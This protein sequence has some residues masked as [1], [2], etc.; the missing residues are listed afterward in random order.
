[1]FYYTFRQATSLAICTIRQSLMAR[2]VGENIGFGAIT[3]DDYIERH[4]TAFLNRLYNGTPQNPKVIVYNDCTYLDIEKSSCFK[5]LRQS[6]CVHKSRHLVKPS[7]LVA[8]DGYLL[9]I[10]GPYFTNAANNNARILLNEFI[11]D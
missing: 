11:A 7:M 2:F 9:D 5:A 1:M 8:P 6:Y 4:V 10:Q 3:R